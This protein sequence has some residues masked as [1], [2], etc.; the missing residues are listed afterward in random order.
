MSENRKPF[1]TFAHYK[2]GKGFA[3]LAVSVDE[4]LVNV[5]IS[6][7]HPRDGIDKS[8]GRA[9]ACARRDVGSDFSFDFTRNGQKLGD[10]LRAEFEGFVVESGKALMLLRG[11]ENQDVRVGA[12]PWAIHSLNRE[13]RKRTRQAMQAHR[14]E[15]ET[16][17]F[18][19]C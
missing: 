14:D 4:G 9:I 15:C 12:P 3:T 17:G 6:Y 7:C 13:L 5:G 18:G 16:P 19:C 8:K 2:V 11:I 10:Q 1:E